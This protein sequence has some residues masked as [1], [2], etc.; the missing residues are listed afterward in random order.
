MPAD[1]DLQEP[2]NKTWN[3]HPD[4]PLTRP[5]TIYTSKP[6]TFSYALAVDQLAVLI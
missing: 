6:A 4:L 5:F 2:I 3:Y 1:G